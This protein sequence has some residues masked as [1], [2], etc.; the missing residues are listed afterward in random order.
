MRN[1]T[2]DKIF[3]K[4]GITMKIL[5]PGKVSRL[6]KFIAAVMA[7]VTPASYRAMT[8]PGEYAAMR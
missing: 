5:S 7:A 1:C 6:K 3:K 8:V 2:L 4:G